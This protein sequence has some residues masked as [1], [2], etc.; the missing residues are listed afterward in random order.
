MVNV[1]SLTDTY[2]KVED[3]EGRYKPLFKEIKEWP[4][5]FYHSSIGSSPFDDPKLEHSL[6]KACAKTEKPIKLCEL[7]IINYTDTTKRIKG[8]RHKMPQ[9]RKSSVALIVQLLTDSL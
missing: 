1:R 6:K 8:L 4:K 3:L 9:V 5:I 7:C 2:I